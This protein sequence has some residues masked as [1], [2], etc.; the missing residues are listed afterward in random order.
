MVRDLLFAD[1]CTLVAHSLEDILQFITDCFANAAQRFGL[2]ISLKKTEVL[3]QPKPGA[4]Y[5][6]PSV[7][8]NGSALKSGQMFTYLGSSLSQNPVLDDEI[9]MRLNKASVAFGSLTRRLWNEHGISIV[10]KV[11]V[12]CAVIIVPLLYS[13]KTWIL[14]RRH[15][16]QLDRFHMCCLRKIA[17]IKWQNRLPNTVV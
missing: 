4:T 8:V 12:Y 14:Y 1:S 16:R 9:A 6:S 7:K 10:T 15:I 11:K 13:C 3:L 2:T 17:N 5:A